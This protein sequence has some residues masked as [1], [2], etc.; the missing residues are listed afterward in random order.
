MEK[1]R[2]MFMV[3]LLMVACHDFADKYKVLYVNSTGI[4]IEKKNVAVAIPKKHLDQMSWYQ[5]STIE[6]IGSLVN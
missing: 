6:S 1:K 3:A 5:I 4:K 2:L